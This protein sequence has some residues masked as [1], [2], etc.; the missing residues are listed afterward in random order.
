MKQDE[1]MPVE[2]RVISRL[3]MGMDVPV[4]LQDLGNLSPA[5]LD[6][7]AQH[8]EARNRVEILKPAPVVVRLRPDIRAGVMRAKRLAQ[9]ERA[10]AD[11]ARYRARLDAIE[12]R[13]NDRRSR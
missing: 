13:R 2:R 6:K 1:L 5:L 11:T 12:S 9:M 7:M 10:E 3:P 8:V 4:E